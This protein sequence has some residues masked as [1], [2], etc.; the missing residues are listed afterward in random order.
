MCGL[1]VCSYVRKTTIRVLELQVERE[2]DDVIN[3]VYIQ[4]DDC[5]VII[6]INVYV[7]FRIIFVNIVYLVF[8][9]KYENVMT[10]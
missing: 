10:S 7:W 2:R 6:V 3:I 5:N 4:Y 1:Y 8:K 9:V